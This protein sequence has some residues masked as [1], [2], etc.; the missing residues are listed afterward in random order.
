M[1]TQCG[2]DSTVLSTKSRIGI[3]GGSF[4][5]PHTGHLIISQYAL[6]ILNLDL[7]YIV[8]TYIPPHKPN[9]LAPFDLRFEWCKIVFTSPTVIVSDYEKTRQDRSYS[10][11]T[12]LH[13]SQ[14]HKTKPYFITGEDS[15]SY[16]ENWYRYEELLKNCHFVVYPRYCNKP[17]QEH[18]K[19][20]LKALYDEIIF[21][22]APLIQ[23]SS[24]EVRKRIKEKRSIKGMVH[25]QIEEQ[26]IEY[27]SL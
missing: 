19:D 14:L 27:Y 9:D 15:L 26:V 13:F 18:A 6:E 8:P 4:N 5:P 24:S 25:P 16:I 1:A 23:V 21:L 12:V 22:D 17:F 20:I 3:F 10:L 2:S 7:L 11:Y